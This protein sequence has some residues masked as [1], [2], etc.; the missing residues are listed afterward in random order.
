MQPYFPGLSVSSRCSGGPTH[1]APNTAKPDFCQAESDKADA[2][3]AL[4]AQSAMI[5]K[6]GLPS[7]DWAGAFAIGQGLK[8]GISGGTI[9]SVGKAAPIGVVATSSW[10]FGKAVVLQAYHS[11][12]ASFHSLTQTVMGC[13]GSL[14]PDFSSPD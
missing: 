4:A 13:H 8:V 6:Q 12:K 3:A 1:N 11:A 9:S 10:F 14:I 5:V 7:L 2:E